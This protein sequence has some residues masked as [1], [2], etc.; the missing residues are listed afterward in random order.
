MFKLM[1]YHALTATLCAHGEFEESAKLIA[2]GEAVF[3]PEREQLI[4]AQIFLTSIGSCYGWGGLSQWFMGRY[5]QALATYVKLAEVVTSLDHRPSEAYMHWTT[6]MLH[7]ARM[8]PS[9][10]LEQATIGLEVSKA[11]NFMFWVAVFELYLGWAR[12]QLGHEQDDARATM[13]RGFA[14]WRAVAPTGVSF[15]HFAVL[16]A[17][18]RA[19]AGALDEALA[20]IDEAIEQLE[21]LPWYYFEPQ[22]HQVRAELLLRRGAPGDAAAAEQALTFAAERAQAIEAPAWVLRVA[23]TRA[24]MWIDRDRARV[25]LE[26]AL[27][28]VQPIDAEVDVR[29]AR[30]MLA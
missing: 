2:A 24:R 14:N 26:R 29:A 19:I 15:P 16:V 25:E 21:T 18:G 27:A 30:A 11:H 22:V 5:E 6:C 1:S 28:A 10:V 8:Q 20:M 7:A 17:Q 3:D 23:L 9:L 13:E 4:L 12:L